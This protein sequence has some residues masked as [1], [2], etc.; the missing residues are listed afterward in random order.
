MLNILNIRGDRHPQVGYLHHSEWCHRWG[1]SPQTCC[2]L[3]PPRSSEAV[4]GTRLWCRIRPPAWSSFTWT[5]PSLWSW[6]LI[7]PNYS[8]TRYT[9]TSHYHNKRIEDLGKFHQIIEVCY[10][11]LW[12]TYSGMFSDLVVRKGRSHTLAYVYGSRPKSS[13]NVCYTFHNQC[14]KWCMV[15]DDVIYRSQIIL[16]TLALKIKKLTRDTERHFDIMKYPVQDKSYRGLSWKWK[17]PINLNRLKIRMIRRLNSEIW[18]VIELKFS[19]FF[20]TNKSIGMLSEGFS[21]F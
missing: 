20:N 8:S 3:S 6:I 17:Y 12:N 15:E 19:C 11:I 13:Y 4:S 10:N 7:M 5:I 18:H 16:A 9:F 14:Q 21:V 2:R 1:T